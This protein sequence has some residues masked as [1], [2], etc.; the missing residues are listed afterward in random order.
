MQKT[1]MV[2]TNFNWIDIG[3]WEEYS[4]IAVK[5]NI[6]I[7]DAPADGKSAGNSLGKR[8][9]SSL[10]INNQKGTNPESTRYCRANQ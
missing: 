2:K 3:N 7:F 9:E 10:C 6:L 1:V 8:R 4:K 5:S